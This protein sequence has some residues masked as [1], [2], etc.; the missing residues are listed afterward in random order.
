MSSSSRSF[1][2]VLIIF[3]C[4]SRH[5]I[6]AE[7]PKSLVITWPTKRKASAST[8]LCFLARKGTKQ[9]CVWVSS[10]FS[11]VFSIMVSL[12]SSRSCWVSL[13]FLWN[14]RRINF[15]YGIDNLGNCSVRVMRSIVCTSFKNQVLSL[16]I[17]ILQPS[18][19]FGM[20]VL[21][22]WTFSICIIRSRWWKA[23]RC[24]GE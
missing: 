7:T 16:I 19:T 11:T 6:K 24:W 13:V 22:T 20:L 3:S 2:L 23:Y 17:A 10:L 21:V 12:T 5:G 18:V 9:W 15:G 4:P 8:H 14:S 1:L